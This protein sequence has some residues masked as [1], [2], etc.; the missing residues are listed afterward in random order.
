MSFT[1]APGFLH[2]YILQKFEIVEKDLNLK[3]NL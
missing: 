3:V 1:L 2:L